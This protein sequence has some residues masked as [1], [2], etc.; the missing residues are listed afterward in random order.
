M[1][2]DIVNKR[3]SKPKIYSGARGQKNPSDLHILFSWLQPLGSVGKRILL[4]FNNKNGE[5]SFSLTFTPARVHRENIERTTVRNDERRKDNFWGDFKCEF[6]FH[7]Q[8]KKKQHKRRIDWYF[9]SIAF[10]KKNALNYSYFKQIDSNINFFLL[11]G[12]TKLWRNNK[13]KVMK[14]LNHLSD[15]SL[16]AIFC[17]HAG[18]NNNNLLPPDIVCWPRLDEGWFLM[19]LGAW[20]LVCS[21]EIFKNDFTLRE[22]SA[23]FFIASNVD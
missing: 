9:A 17:F 1:K 19:V 21:L 11:L 5:K 2:R 15:L 3:A 20:K 22:S 6:K 16:Q 18:C 4:E 13:K 10:N 12:W 14:D 7:L 8:N 23:K